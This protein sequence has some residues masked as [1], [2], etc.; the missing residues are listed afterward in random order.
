MVGLSVPKGNG[1]KGEMPGSGMRENHEFLPSVRLGLCPDRAS[2]SCVTFHIA[3]L[4][5]P[6]CA[7]L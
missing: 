4:S 2:C 3:L 6:Q 7:H 1:E 5:E